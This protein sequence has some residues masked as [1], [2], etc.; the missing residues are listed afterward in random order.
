MD[1]IRIVPSAVSSSTRC[2]SVTD[3]SEAEAAVARLEALCERED[4]ASARGIAFVVDY[5]TTPTSAFSLPRGWLCG[6]C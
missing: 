4:A 2:K 6:R 1:R 3:Q 5:H